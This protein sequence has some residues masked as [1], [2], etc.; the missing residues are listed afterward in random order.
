MLVTHEPDQRWLTEFTGEDGAVLLTN[1]SVTLITDGRFS[2]T[3]AME[4]PWAKAVIRKKRGPESIAKVINAS[5]AKRIGFDPGTL[6][7]AQHSGIRKALKTA[8]LVATEGIIANLR[9]CK[10]AG[11]IARIRRAIDVAERAMKKVQRFLKPG[12]TEIEIAARLEFE[13]R[14]L[15]ASG[16]SFPPIVAAGANSSLP[17][18]APQDRKLKANDVVLIDWG[19]IVDG[20][21]SDLTR[22]FALGRVAQR[23][24][25]IHA[26]VDE[27]RRK[28]IAAVRPGVTSG[29]LD[30]IARQHIQ[31][32]GFGP[33]FSHSLGH[34]IGLE[35]HEAPGLRAMTDT[36][37]QTGM[38]ITIEPGIY[39]PSVGGIRLEDDV[40]VTEDGH[41]VLT[42][43]PFTQL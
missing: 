4:A 16:P 35:V 36:V 10:D 12:A 33:Q 25:R 40:L 5:R 14:K 15:G 39:L 38:V 3:A 17:H 27:A 6:T 22:I 18:Y 32:A 13:M 1:K 8:K 23:M 9:Q 21:V 29:E 2:E 11:E 7:V 43:Y 28:A 37:L 31:K 42:Q 41:E 26:I 34:G 24:A 20:Y 30:R 19:A